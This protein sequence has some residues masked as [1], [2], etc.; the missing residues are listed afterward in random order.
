MHEMGFSC[1]LNR[2]WFYRVAHKEAMAALIC[3]SD[4][5]A[6]TAFSMSASE[7]AELEPS[8]RRSSVN[9]TPSFWAISLTLS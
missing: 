1:H 7:M 9:G 6:A 8:L 4:F 5:P 3:S 2:V